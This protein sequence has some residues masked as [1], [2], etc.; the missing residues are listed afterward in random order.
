MDRH[1]DLV[2]RRRQ[3]ESESSSYFKTGILPIFWG[4]FGWEQDFL[5]VENRKML[6]KHLIQP[7][8]LKKTRQKCSKNVLSILVKAPPAPLVINL[9]SPCKAFLLT[10]APGTGRTAATVAAAQPDLLW[11]SPDTRAWPLHPKCGVQQLGQGQA[12]E[13]IGLPL[14]VPLC[15]PCLRDLRYQALGQNL[16]F[17]QSDQLLIALWLRWGLRT[18]AGRYCSVKS[19]TV[20]RTWDL[21]RRQMWEVVSG[22]RGPLSLI[23]WHCHHCYLHSLLKTSL[24]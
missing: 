2:P 20:F 17:T 3:Y 7:H 6:I 5:F 8:I 24:W 14:S 19:I 23:W 4:G 15:S 18:M 1:K 16:E 21:L 9:I 11:Q 10:Q 13:C 22:P 12:A